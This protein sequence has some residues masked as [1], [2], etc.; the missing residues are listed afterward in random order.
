MNCAAPMDTKSPA[1]RW[2]ARTAAVATL[3]S[4]QLVWMGVFAC[5]VRCAKGACAAELAAAASTPAGDCGH[6]GTA[7][8]A[9]HG[10]ECP[11][12]N[13]HNWSAAAPAV[14]APQIRVL[15]SPQALAGVTPRDADCVFALA[16]G[17]FLAQENS[18]WLIVSISA[19]LPL[20]I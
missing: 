17:A 5:A 1:M 7:P 8:D 9:P 13:L 18:P 15:S 19:P 2:L 11:A 16:A 20:R 3:I 10:R 12:S 6:S 4:L 14:S